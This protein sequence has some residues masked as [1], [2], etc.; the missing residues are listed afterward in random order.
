MG[1]PFPLSLPSYPTFTCL[2]GVPVTPN[3]SL[4]SLPPSPPPPHAPEHANLVVPYVP[5]V[6]PSMPA[7]G[8]VF[9]DVDGAIAVLTATLFVPTPADDLVHAIHAMSACPSVDNEVALSQ[10]GESLVCEALD[11]VADC[12][13]FESCIAEVKHFYWD[14]REAREW[15]Q[16]AAVQWLMTGR[17]PHVPVNTEPQPAGQGGK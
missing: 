7:L 16:V 13:A 1:L 12:V 4:P 6:P 2:Q 5:N 14:D 15:V 9:E 11:L 3:A 10:M 17:R 8:P